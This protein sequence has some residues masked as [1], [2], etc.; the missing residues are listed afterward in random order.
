MTREVIRPAETVQAMA[1]RLRQATPASVELTLDLSAPEDTVL[2]DAS[3]LETVL[4]DLVAVG[5]E[6]LR[7]AGRLK[8]SV[9]IEVLQNHVVGAVS[10]SGDHLVIALQ[11]EGEVVGTPRESD[12]RLASI[13]GMV[14]QG[15]GHVEI[16]TEESRISLRV[17]L[18]LAAAQD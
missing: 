12:P 2:F 14:T 10:L 15:G 13:Q 8:L 6:Q 3:Q 4:L 17:L 11:V 7:G 16:V 9:D 1:D 18:P 5:G